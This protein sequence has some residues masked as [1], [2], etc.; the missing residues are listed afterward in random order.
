MVHQIVAVQDAKASAFL[1]PVFFANVGQ[2]IRLFGDVCAQKDSSFYVHPEDYALYKLGE[3]N[4]N[5]GIITP[6]HT[7]EY[8]SRATDFVS[9]KVNV[10]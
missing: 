2:A 1:T 8:L 10:I 5:S 7:P 3:Y 9:A 6:L 4:D